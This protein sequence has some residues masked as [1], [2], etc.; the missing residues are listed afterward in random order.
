MLLALLVAIA[1]SAY[2]LLVMALCRMAAQAD[3]A[4]GMKREIGGRR[5]ERAVAKLVRLD[6]QSALP[7]RSAPGVLLDA[8][9]HPKR[10]SARAG[11]HRPTA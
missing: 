3:I 5:A 8:T 6:G 4:L 2:A 7:L 10:S 11:R 1:L 9:G